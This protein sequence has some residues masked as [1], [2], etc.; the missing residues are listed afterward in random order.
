MINLGTVLFV[1][2]LALIIIIVYNIIFA[3][4]CHTLPEHMVDVSPVTNPQWSRTECKYIIGDTMQ[5]VMSEHNI[6]QAP[7]NNEGNSGTLQLTCGYDEIDNEINKITPKD[8]QR[9]FIVHNADHVSAKDFLWNRLISSA[10]IDKAK[11]IMPNT[12]ILADNVDRERLKNDFKVGKLYIMKKNIQRQEGLQITDSLDEIL[13]A[14]SSFVLAQELLQNP[15]VINVSKSAVPDNRK[16]NMRFYVLVICKEKNM[17]VY[18]FN[19][20]FMYYT[21][22]AFQKNSKEIGPNV[23]TG[24]IDRWIYEQNPLT[25]A[26]FRNYLDRTDRNLILGEQNIRNQGLK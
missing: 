11:T 19:D 25:H 17:D 23:T 5:K 2:L 4:Y 8:N 26:D 3:S 9:I 7:V 20:G 24:Y 15:Y 6:T 12:Y 14:P 18:V 21:N 16:I 13:K 1:I 22:V 10:G